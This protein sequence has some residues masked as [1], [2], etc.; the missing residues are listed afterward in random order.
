MRVGD[1]ISN[2]LVVDS[3]WM[4]HYYNSKQVGRDLPDAIEAW[5]G[6]K[7]LLSFLELGIGK[8]SQQRDKFWHQVTAWPL[9]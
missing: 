3:L 6:I 7:V 2:H 1:S 9:V 4:V 8:P 5:L